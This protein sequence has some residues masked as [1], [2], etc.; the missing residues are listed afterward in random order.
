MRAAFAFTMRGAKM[1]WILPKSLTAVD[2][3]LQQY[4][5]GKADGWCEFE[6]HRVGLG[7]LI[8]HLR[9]YQLGKFATITLY[10]LSEQ[11]TRMRIAVLRLPPLASK[12]MTLDD[13]NAQRAQRQE[14]L[15]QREAHLRNVTKYVLDGMQIDDEDLK[16]AQPTEPSAGDGRQG[17]QK[18]RGGRPHYAEDEWAADELKRGRPRDEVVKD[19]LEKTK[20]SGRQFVD[21]QESFDKQMSA[22]RKRREKTAKTE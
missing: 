18:N 1:E 21:F 4:L 22:V 5:P 14:L 2:A 7:K 15:A 10:A 9:Q 19:W 11:V 20:A 13:F 8:Y 3:A 12:P 6:L 16:L 17:K